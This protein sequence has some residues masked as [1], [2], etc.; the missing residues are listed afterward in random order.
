MD[1]EILSLIKKQCQGKQHIKLTVGYISNGSTTI[2]VFNED[3]ETD[4]QDY[5]YEI[6]SLTK[7]FTASLL[8]KYLHEGK[9]SLDDSIGTYIHGLEQNRYYPTIKRLMTHT[10]GFSTR[11]PM[12]RTEYLSA[13]FSEI[14]NERFASMLYMD[15][16]KMKAI[17]RSTN[18]S[19]KDY[20]WQYSNFGV[21][22]VGYAI[23]VISGKGYTATMD[24]F[25]ANELGLPNSYT[26]TYPGKNLL[27]FNKNVTNGGNVVWGENLL[28]P[29]GDISSSAK[30]LLRFAEVNFNE[31]LPY[32]SVCHQKHAKHGFLFTRLFD[33]DMGL[34]WWI[35]KKENLILNGGDTAVFSS[36]LIADKKNK[37]ATVVLSNYPGNSYKLS[38]IA[39][40]L[41]EKINRR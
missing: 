5:L 22:L 30:D 4:Y 7:T 37:T 13:A 19:D 8:A 31:E 25:L 11:L 40:P 32:L 38:K 2:S 12:S 24:E 39:L 6:G 34:G 15:E 20:K 16:R 18:L 21:A 33:L 9:I 17:L 29:A 27:G 35:R 41:L 10:S 1:A 26:G 3:G 23:G 36:F 14:T 28:R